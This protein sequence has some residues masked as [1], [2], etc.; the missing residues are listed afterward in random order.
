MRKLKGT[1]ESFP[2]SNL[3]KDT[4]RGRVNL[5]GPVTP[6]YLLHGEVR[7]RAELLLQRATA[8]TP[9]SSACLC[10][11]CSPLLFSH[12]LTHTHTHMET[13]RPGTAAAP[14]GPAEEPGTGRGPSRSSFSCRP[15]GTFGKPQNGNQINK[16]GVS[17][18]PHPHVPLRAT[19]ASR[20]CQ[21]ADGA[22]KSARSRGVPALGGVLG[23]GQR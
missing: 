13:Q 6:C 11:V 21:V 10:R 16:R 2:L 22:G 17:G 3:P 14:A 19:S 12:T 8:V 20:G 9:C 5:Q 1:K 23:P 15:A 4:G 7:N 18:S